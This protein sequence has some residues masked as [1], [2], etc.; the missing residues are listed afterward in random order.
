MT[1]ILLARKELSRSLEN[2]ST[3]KL[4]MY[5]EQ[6]EEIAAEVHKTRKYSYNNRHHSESP[7]PKEVTA[8]TR[9]A[10]KLITKKSTEWQPHKKQLN[11]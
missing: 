1:E 5:K 7:Q 4:S 2:I 9:N 10:P 11:T 6:T 8:G 3:E